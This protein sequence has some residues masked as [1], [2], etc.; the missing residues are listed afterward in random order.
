MTPNPEQPL[1][2]H[3]VQLLEAEGAELRRCDVLI[4]A[5]RLTAMGGDA[6]AQAT[7]CGAQVLD[8]QAWLLAPPLVDPHSELEDPANGSAESLESL[9]RS[10]LAAGYGTVALLP[11]ASSWRDRPERLQGLAPLGRL[12]LLLWGSFS[13]GASGADLAPHGDQLAAGAI[14][15]AE[16]D[17]MP[18]LALLER[19]LSLGECG[20]APVLLA[21]R[22]A[23]LSQGGFVREGVE[24]LRAGWPTDPSISETLP[25]QN[26]LAM[27]RRHPQRRLQLMNLSTAE[28]A[29]LLR[30]LPAE[31]RPEAT[32]CWWHLLADS[33]SLDPIAEGWRVVPPLGTPADRLALQQALADGVLTAVAVHHQALDAEEQLLPLDQRKP[34]VAGH[35]FVLPCLWQELVVECGWSA[36]QIWRALCFAPARLLGLTPPSL[37]PGSDQWV[38]FDPSRQWQP[39]KDSWGPQAANQPAAT[40]TLTGQVLASG[41]IPEL[42]RWPVSPA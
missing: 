14:G 1:L 7:A 17:Q 16:A 35:R 36:E 19:G 10:A 15:L 21:P 29:C 40:G 11:R 28:G 39:S 22:D 23:S 4:Q 33:G 6:A 9:E 2:L 12:Q 8:A 38:V 5:G 32:V 24:A 34:G 25:L 31:Q 18:A 27:A 37:S 26:L 20:E 3:Q 13:H 42:N 30:E 41:L